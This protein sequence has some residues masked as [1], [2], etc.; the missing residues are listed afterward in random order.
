MSLCGH[1]P[2]DPAPGVAEP[3]LFAHRAGN[4]L[5]SLRRAEALG[6]DAVEADVRLFNGRLELRHMKTVG[7]VPVYWDRWHVARPGTRFPELDDLL[8]AAQPATQLMLDL[9]GIDRRLAGGVLAAIDRSGRRDGVTVCSRRWSHLEPFVGRDGV[10]VVH[11]V[12]NRSQLRALLRRPSGLDGISIH[13]RLLTPAVTAE[14]RRRAPLVLA[15]SVNA[16]RPAARLVEW[17]VNGLI[18]DDPGRL[19]GMLAA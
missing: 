17:G 11:S 13:Q 14:L 18:S 8:E 5:S 16:V 19:R 10:R 6:V 12:G 15:W 7:P 1:T 9:K 4:D 3:L 2:V